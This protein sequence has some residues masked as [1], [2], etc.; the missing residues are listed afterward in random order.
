M[1]TFDF[2]SS[3]LDIEELAQ[4]YGLLRM[5]KMPELK[6]KKFPNFEQAEIDVSKITFK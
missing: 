6:G 1:K 2:D 5:P 4:G 3:D